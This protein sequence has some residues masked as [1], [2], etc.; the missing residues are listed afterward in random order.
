M[1]GLMVKLVAHGDEAT[2]G[3]AA[4]VCTSA[5]APHSIFE[6]I[7][8]QE[9]LDTLDRVMAM[10]HESVSEH[11]YFTFTI[12]GI[13]RAC[14]HQLV[15]HRIASYSQ[16]SQRYVKEGGFEFVTPQSIVATGCE[17]TFKDAMFVVQRAYDAMI[18][19]GVPAEDARFVL[20]NA[21]TT[22]LVMTM[23]A[24]ALTHFFHE[25]LCKTSQWEIRAM[26]HQMFDLAMIA[27]PTLFDQ[28]GPKCVNQRYCT[29][30]KARCCGY[31]PHWSDTVVLT[32]ESANR[33]AVAVY[34]AL[35]EGFITPEQTTELRY[36]CD[37]CCSNS[38]CKFAFD[39]YNIGGDCLAEK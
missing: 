22:S 39:P 10:G 26:A 32:T 1:A 38:K 4:R 9:A 12:D 36:R 23:S 18:K 35:H 15:R 19:R 11:M 30:S 20:P 5:E 34:D 24:R 37:L 29:E 2:C 27:A 14:S 33:R 21:C 13:S 8:D 7:S 25:R 16:K 17:S 6:S 3:K 28:V 31:R